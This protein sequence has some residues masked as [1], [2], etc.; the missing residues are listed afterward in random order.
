MK[1]VF[2]KNI[3]EQLISR[4]GEI[5]QN[6]KAEWGKMN[7]FQML[8]HNTYWN[9]WMLGKDI[10]TYKQ[11]FMGKI[12]GKIALKKMIKDEKPF[13]KNIPT[14]DQFKARELAGD[15]ESEKSK[16]ISLIHEYESYNNPNFV[17]DFFGK[18]TKEQVGILT[19]KHTDHHLRQFGV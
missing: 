18:M 13:D 11:T 5:N 6:N 8:K 16:W 10:H 4:I 14:S 1:T 9:E 12:F 15:L 19:Y 2:D 17:H 7:V 3:R